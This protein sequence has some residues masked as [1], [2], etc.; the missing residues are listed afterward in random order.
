M[1]KRVL[2]GTDGS[3]TATRAVE[4]AARVARAHGAELIIANAFAPRLTAAQQI[5]Q[6]D[7]PVELRWRLSPGVLSESTVAAAIERVQEASG[8]TVPVRGRC[9]PGHPVP[10]LLKLVDELDLDVLVIGNRDMPLR[11]RAHRSVG[12]ALSRR[13]PCDVVIVDTIGRRERQNVGG[14]HPAV[15]WT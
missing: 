1:Y 6:R 9:E 10:V 8:A 7:A 12:R 5:A 2:V 14:R 13:A 4:A 15:R 11:L 3:A